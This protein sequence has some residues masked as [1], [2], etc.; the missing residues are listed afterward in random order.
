[1]DGMLFK[2]IGGMGPLVASQRTGV[3]T[4][5]TGF[6]SIGNITYT[7]NTLEPP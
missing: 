4:L 2:V 3:R 1:M 7:Q 6:L 5:V